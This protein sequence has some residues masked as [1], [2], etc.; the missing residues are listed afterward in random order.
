MFPAVVRPKLG[1]DTWS[2]YQMMLADH[3]EAENAAPR[4]IQT[5]C[6]AVEQLGP[7]CGQQSRLRL[8]CRGR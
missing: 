4:V 1:R 7:S 8:E 3:L 5:Y 2:V 6:L